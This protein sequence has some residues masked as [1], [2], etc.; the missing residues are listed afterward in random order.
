[1]LEIGGKKVNLDEIILHLKDNAI[2]YQ[3][4][5]NATWQDTYKFASIKNVVPNGIYYFE[6]TEFISRFNIENSILIVS[7]A[8][9]VS[10]GNNLI[11]V[12]NPQ[13]AHYLLC[14]S[15]NKVKIDGI[16]ASSKINSEATIGENVSIG[17]N[18]VI[19][20]CILEDGVVLKHN[21]VI[22]DNVIIKKNTFIDSNSVIGAGGLA[23]I[24]N[25]NGERIIQPQL[26]GVI[27]EED[28][29][30][31][32]DIT[33]VKGSLSECTTIGKGTVM[34]HGTKIGHGVQLGEQ[35][36]IANNVS[37]AGNA[38]V[39]N[40]CFLGSACVISSNISVIENCIVGAGAVVVAHVDESFVTLAG[41]PA[42]IIKRNNYN[43]K[44]N[45]APKPF[46]K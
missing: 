33:I 41:V 4:V 13:L 30:L 10:S 27:I 7:E 45:G 32:T 31:A 37:I 16:S 17:E 25:S 36:H 19:G 34:A 22:E 8:V 12:E 15:I 14:A 40:R 3:I 23:W 1:M 43:G 11:I 26:G 39:G 5:E 2:D 46:K 35:V 21:V 20:K 18:C 6:N 42:K 9:Q 38:R 44:P 29:I 24:W 28:C